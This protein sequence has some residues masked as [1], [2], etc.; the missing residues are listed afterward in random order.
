M[1][2]FEK[3]KRYVVVILMTFFIVV[4]FYYG[5]GFLCYIKILKI[6]YTKNIKITKTG[7]RKVPV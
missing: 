1:K 6:S 3:I 4:G 7:T 2:S 5:K